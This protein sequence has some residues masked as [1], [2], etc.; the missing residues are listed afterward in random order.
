MNSSHGLVEDSSA[1]RYSTDA[2]GRF[3]LSGSGED[4]KNIAVSCRAVD[5]WIVPA[6]SADEAAK[7]FEIRLPEPGKLI[8]HYDIPGGAEE[9]T[10]FLQ[11]HTWDREGWQGVD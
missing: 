2:D 5:L 4:A 9:A 7:G 6:P 11:L 10:I 8:V 1:V 3:T